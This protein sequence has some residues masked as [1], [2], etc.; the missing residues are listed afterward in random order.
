MPRI[1]A[2][3]RDA[4]R[5][6]IV[7]AAR[8]CFAR[9]GFHRTSMPDIAAE[10]GVSVGAPYRHFSSKDELILE[11]AGQA[12]G[13]L[14]APVEELAGS[15][16][17]V[18]LAD[19]VVSCVEA[20]G[21]HVPDAAGQEVPVEELLRCA[22]QAWAEVLRDDH[23]RRQANAGF[24]RVRDQMARALRRAQ[25]RGAVPAGLDPDRGARVVIALLHGFVLQRVAFGLQDTDGFTRDVRAVL[26]DAGVLL[27]RP[28]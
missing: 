25:T 24:D 23:L 4:R 18:A 11:I 17:G 12:F 13:A 2:Q 22:V 21:H 9:D 10:A 15:T 14:F 28:R 19:L 7:G 6:E 8:R 27:S 20:A 16:G 26:V 1:T 5:A 3:R